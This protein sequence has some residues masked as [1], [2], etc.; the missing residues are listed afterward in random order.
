MGTYINSG[1]AGFRQIA[2]PNYVDKT[3]LINLINERINA[4][5][6]LI[7]VSRP[8]R[9]GK[10]YAA[11]MLTAYYDCKCDSHRLFDDKKIAECDSYEK[12]LNQYNVISL[13][14]TSFI[15]DAKSNDIPLKEVPKMIMKELQ[16]ELRFL[17]AKLSAKKSLNSGFHTIDT[18]FV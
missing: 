9:F 8:R 17:N 14:I 15:S 1:N 18:I 5:N 16:S 12:H 2:G 4:E 13:D 7:C 3:M 11:K 6:N 10:S